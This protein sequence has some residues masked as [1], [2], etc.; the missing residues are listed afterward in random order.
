MAGERIHELEDKD[1][2]MT[3]KLSVMAYP[4]NSSTGKAEAGGLP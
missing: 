4:H 1:E 3:Q 2:E